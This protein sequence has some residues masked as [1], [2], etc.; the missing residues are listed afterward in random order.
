MTDLILFPSSFFNKKK[1]DE[2]LQTEYDAVV[3]TG[4]YDIAIFGYEAWFD[5]GQLIL[6]IEPFAPRTAIYRGWMMQPEQYAEFYEKL[7]DHNITLVTPPEAYRLMHIFPNV[8]HLVEADTAKIRGSRQPVLHGGLC[9]TRG[10]CL[11]DH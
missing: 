6:D 11:E 1:V 3:A 8:Y 7:R 9:R 2:D 10:R 5:D 4:L